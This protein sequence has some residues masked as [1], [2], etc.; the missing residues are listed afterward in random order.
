MQGVSIR[1]HLQGM[2]RA[3][4][5]R[6]YGRSKL[7]IGFGIFIWRAARDS[8]PT[9]QNLRYRHVPVRDSCP[10]C[11]EYS[12][13]LIHCLWLCEHAQVVWKSNINFVRFYRK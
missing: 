2:D 6:R 8:L 9:K 12:E 11:D 4:S 1:G 10:T 7:R 5:G 13:S 3:R